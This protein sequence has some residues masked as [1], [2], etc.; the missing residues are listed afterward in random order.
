M[1]QITQAKQL[2]V[3]LP[4]FLFELLIAPGC[5]GL[6]LQT[7]QLCIQLFA[8]IF[9]TAQVFPCMAHPGFGLPSPVFVMRDAGCFLHKGAEF[10]WTR[11]DNSADHPLLDNGIGAV[12]QSGPPEQIRN[13][14]P[15]T[16]CFIEPVFRSPVSGQSPFN[17]DLAE[18]R[19]G[20]CTF[21][22]GIVKHQFD[23]CFTDRLSR[24]R[25]IEND[26]RHAVAPQLPGGTLTHD[27][28]Y[29]VNHIGLATAVWSDDAS[30]VGR[31]RD[32]RGVDEGLETGYVNF[33]KAHVLLKPIVNAR[34]TTLRL[35]RNGSAR[36]KI[37][38]RQEP[39]SVL[40][41]I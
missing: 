25:S 29:G 30:H 2:P 19:I 8:D 27:P 21:S 6:A 16:L 28:A 36:A 23:G 7:T 31:N 14:P 41:I 24:F 10:L 13:V 26:V 9:D 32:R 3:D 39:S 5:L 4:F 15:P 17:S 34:Q 22:I 20:L 40:T 35:T 38:E 37:K 12:A 33:L 1:R 11:L 18:T